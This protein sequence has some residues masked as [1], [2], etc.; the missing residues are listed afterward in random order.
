[1][2][3]SKNLLLGILAAII[4]ISIVGL[5]TTRGDPNAPGKYDEFAQCLTEKGVVIA[6]T[7]WCS[8]CKS[9]KRVF[10]NSFKHLDYKNCDIDQNWCTVNFIERYP[11]WII[12]GSQY[13]GKKSLA[14][15]SE[16]SGCPVQ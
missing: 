11:T 3:I 1:M 9:Q 2:K 15:L 13:T 12:D 8:V 10:G 14:T 4:I 16:L 7:D 5:Y 6:G